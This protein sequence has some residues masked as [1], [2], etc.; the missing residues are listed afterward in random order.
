[1]G[2]DFATPP[3]GGRNKILDSEKTAGAVN[4]WIKS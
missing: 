1:M 3:D 4:E 2:Y